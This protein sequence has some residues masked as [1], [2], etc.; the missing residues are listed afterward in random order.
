LEIFYYRSRTAHWSSR[1]GAYLTP[2]FLRQLNTTAEEKIPQ[3][4]HIHEFRTGLS[5]S[6]AAFA[7]ERGIPLVVSTHGSLFS[8][9]SVGKR[10]LKRIFDLA[11]GHR[12]ASQ[13]ACFHAVCTHEAEQIERLGVSQKKIRVI[14]HGFSPAGCSREN[15][16]RKPPFPALLFAGRIDPIKGLDTLLQAWSLVTCQYPET[17][18][19]LLGHG[20]PGYI[21]TLT[22]RFGL[23]RTVEPEWQAGKAVYGGHA[24]PSVVAERLSRASCLAVPSNY[25]IWGLV[26]LESLAAGC[27]VVATQICGCLEYLDG[28]S[29]VTVVPAEH[30]ESLAE[31]LK[32]VIT[33]PPPVSS[34][35]AG[36]SWQCVAEEMVALY[37]REIEN[38][39]DSGR[40]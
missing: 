18:L 34:L 14:P 21:K 38:R 12:L 3:V 2:G 11:I 26:I 33:A 9:C 4:V 37:C 7:R 5:L 32:A 25:E 31:A 17:G 19:L 24:S 39:T 40:K 8:P 6:A 13:T 16:M 35:P 1:I 15:T 27:P 28:V 29:G 36:L 22:V 20:D 23:L 10:A 30:V